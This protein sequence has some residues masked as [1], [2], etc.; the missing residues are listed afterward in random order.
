MSTPNIK[1]FCGEES[2]S[3]SSESEENETQEFAPNPD[4]ETSES[5]DE[6]VKPKK[7]KRKQAQPVKKTVDSFCSL[8][9]IEKE[10]GGQFSINSDEFKETTKEKMIGPS[11]QS[12][13]ITNIMKLQRSTNLLIPRLS[14]GRLV[15]E[16]LCEVTNIPNIRVTPE[17]LEAIQQSAELY[18]AQFFQ[19]AYLCTCHRDRVTL[20][21]KDLQLAKRLRGIQ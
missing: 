15:K 5:D 9:P 12:T 1:R 7:K 13:L 11:K 19:D 18:L 10:P 17:F 8:S 4:D 6:A 16:V 21:P 3:E 20:I 2:C 14:F